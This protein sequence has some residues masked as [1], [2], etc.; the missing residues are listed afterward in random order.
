VIPE[1]L[2]AHF[3]NRL[4]SAASFVIPETLLA[5]HAMA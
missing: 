2:L 1:T 3:V 5:G 4:T